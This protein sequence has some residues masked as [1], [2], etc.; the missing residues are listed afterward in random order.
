M[1]LYVNKSDQEHE[2]RVLR[3]LEKKWT[4]ESV[5]SLEK[6]ASFDGFLHRDGRPTALVE[7]RRL[8]CYSNSFP[9]AMISY[10]KIQNW[11]TLYPV[12]N[13]P[14]LFVVNWLDQV[15]YANI[16]DI[17]AHRDIRVSPVSKNRRNPEE[18]REIVFYYPVKEFKLLAIDLEAEI[19]HDPNK[20]D[21][22]D[23]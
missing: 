21:K 16:E 2:E 13:L 12:L 22:Y 18:D 20:I 1:T 5:R 14:C 15:R 8:N 10:T 6:K 9:D 3:F 7:I 11:Q 23:P 17:I 19:M 4:C